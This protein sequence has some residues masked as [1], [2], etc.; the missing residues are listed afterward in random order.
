MDV[1]QIAPVRIYS[2]RPKY[3]IIGDVYFDREYSDYCIFDGTDW[4]I[5]V[6]QIENLA[7]YTPTNA[8]LE[9]YPALKQAWEEYL[10]IRKLLGIK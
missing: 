4:H 2:V 8:Q 9:K 1:N 5:G 3:P 10:V 6:I 7:K